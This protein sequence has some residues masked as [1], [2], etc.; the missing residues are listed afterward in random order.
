MLITP[1][2]A[3]Q[4]LPYLQ[5]AHQ[6]VSAVEL[7]EYKTLIAFDPKLSQA[8]EESIKSK[9]I[10]AP[11]LLDELHQLFERFQ[12][13]RLQVIHENIQ[14]T[15]DKITLILEPWQVNS[16]KNSAILPARF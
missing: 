2:Q 13:K 16:I 10:T 9:R 4:I 6:K 11:E 12:Q 1:H 8:L 15:S 7:E 3:K 14:E 5:K